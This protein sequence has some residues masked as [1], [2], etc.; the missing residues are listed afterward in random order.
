MIF[1]L[2]KTIVGA[3]AIAQV[4]AIEGTGSATEPGTHLSYAYNGM[5]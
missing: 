5:D 4:S 1:N 3:M 2:F